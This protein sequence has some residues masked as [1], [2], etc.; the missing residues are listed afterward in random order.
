[1]LPEPGDSRDRD[2]RVL[3][4]HGER[5][6]GLSQL[7][8]QRLSGGL[9]RF[10]HIGVGVCPK[11]LLSAT[12]RIGGLLPAAPVTDRRSD[13]RDGQRDTACCRQDRL[14][15]RWQGA[16]P[17][18]REVAQQPEGLL[19]GEETDG[20][21]DGMQC[22]QDA[23]V[24]RRVQHATLLADHVKRARSGDAPDVVDDQQT[25]TRCQRIAQLP[26]TCV[27]RVQ[28][29]SIAAKALK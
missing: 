19:L 3:G 13:E 12:E 18:P 21:C 10:E 2:A 1:M 14:G 7:R 29:R 9:H 26:R 28:L 11:R 25:A 6:I 17:H 5:A 8:A 20:L 27:D 24:A 22:I 15:G 23:A 4:V 16:I